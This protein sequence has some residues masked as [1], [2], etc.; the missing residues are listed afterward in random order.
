MG[1]TEKL[2]RAAKGGEEESGYHPDLENEIHFQDARP[3]RVDYN[4]GS[5]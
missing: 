2:A 5:P 4:R 1:Q 3:R